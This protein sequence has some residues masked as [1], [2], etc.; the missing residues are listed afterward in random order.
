[1]AGSKAFDDVVQAQFKEWYQR[2]EVY[3]IESARTGIIIL[4]QIWTD[5]LSIGRRLTSQ[6]MATVQKMGV[7]LMLS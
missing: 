7:N 1:M 2:V 6:W 5:G 3:D 4:E